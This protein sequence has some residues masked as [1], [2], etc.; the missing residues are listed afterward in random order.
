MKRKSLSILIALI[1]CFSAASVVLT[2]GSADV[3]RQNG[4][5]YTVSAETEQ[6]VTMREIADFLQDK[7]A[8]Y[9]FSDEFIERY[10]QSGGG[11]IDTAKKAGLIVDKQKHEPNQKW[12]FFDSWL[13]PSIDDGSLTWDADAKRRV[14]TGLLCPE[15]LLWI[16]EASGVDPVKVSNAKTVAE[17]GK[18]AG[19]N[20]STIAKNMRACVP[21]E[22]IANNVKGYKP[23]DSITLNTSNLR[24]TVGENATIT[25]TVRAQDN[26]GAVSWSVTEGGDVVTISPNGNVLT[27][28]AV[29][30]GTAKIKATYN[31]TLSAE[32][33]VTVRE[34][35]VIT[36]DFV[37]KYNLQGT[38]TAQIKTNENAFAAFKL[39]GDGN[40]LIREVSAIS[41]IYGGGSGG[42]N[43]T[44]WSSTE[45]LKLGTT[46]I[47][48]SI[49]LELNAKVIGVK[50]TG[51][52]HSDKCEIRVGDSTSADWTADSADNKTSTYQCSDMTVVSKEAVENNQTSTIVI[53]FESTSSV[54]L[55]TINTTSTKY[56][57]Y[58]TSIEFILDSDVAQ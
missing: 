41:G 14:Y 44:K 13:Y 30:A 45:M 23:S 40:G 55:A 22:D 33:T 36:G 20:V 31:E 7:N 18:A 8:H 51:Y 57:L 39:D 46:S 52:V 49:T 24:L 28:S 1:F 21:W 38:S 35:S 48:G 3:S 26:T 34:Q 42:R 11:Y 56:P 4:T 37:T 50:I 25:A 10:Q 15:L 16:Y 47:V 27:V 32:C 9:P 53:N 17:Q 19:T 6:T 54:T 58:I 43:E 29:S 2:N 12:H 5:S